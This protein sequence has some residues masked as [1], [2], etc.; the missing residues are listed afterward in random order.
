MVQKMSQLPKTLIERFS[1]DLNK[2]ISEGRIRKIT[3]LD[4][5]QTVVSLNIT[6]FLINPLFREITGLNNVEF[7]KLMSKRK[8]ENV[9]I[10]MR[11]LMP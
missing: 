11:S 4:L 10:I 6:P 1:D 3:P 8:Q 9:L 5:L 2:E 7:Q